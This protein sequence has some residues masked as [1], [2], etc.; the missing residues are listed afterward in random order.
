MGRWLE[1][2][3]EWQTTEIAE[4]LK[5]VPAPRGG[6]ANGYIHPI[7]ENESADF[8]TLTP[9]DTPSPIPTTHKKGT[10]SVCG[11]L[12]SGAL[13]YETEHSY[14]PLCSS[15]CMLRLLDGIDIKERPQ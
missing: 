11:K 14:K 5:I 8:F 13:R 15:K 7:V 9:E 12:C 3:K 10:C 2:L 6:Y 4:H 1:K